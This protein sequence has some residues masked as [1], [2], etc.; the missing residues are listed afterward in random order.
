LA[1]L[2]CRITF[3][4]PFSSNRL[5]CTANTYGGYSAGVNYAL[6]VNPYVRNANYCDFLLSGFAS[7]TA[8]M[9]FVI[10]EI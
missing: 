8:F 3:T 2:G 1:Q 9:D 6:G 4:V 5:I 10:R 7:G